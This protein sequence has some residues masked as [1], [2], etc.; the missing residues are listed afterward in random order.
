M[1]WE[2]GRRFKRRGHTY[3]YGYFM[4]MYD[5][6]NQYYKVINYSSIKN[7]SIKKK[8]KKQV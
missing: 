6:S 5:K 4:L 2:V 3:T 7:K 1:G 8:K